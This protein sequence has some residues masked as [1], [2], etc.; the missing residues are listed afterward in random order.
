MELV[1]PPAASGRGVTGPERKY[2]V[3][4][5]GG[6]RVVEASVQPWLSAERKACRGLA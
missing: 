1:K 2:K 3:E 5:A 6:V 4:F